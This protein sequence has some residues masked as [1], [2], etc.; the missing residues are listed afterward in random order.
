[1]IA[2]GK[3]HRCTDNCSI[4]AYVLFHVIIYLVAISVYVDV[5]PPLKGIV[6]DG[7]DPNSDEIYSS[8]A[9]TV[10]CVWRGF[11]DP[12]S[13]IKQYGVDVYRTSAGMLNV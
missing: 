1:M 13:G 5:T 7:N 4:C 10:S 6:K 3:Q 2:T 8:E 9:S 11:S 12:E